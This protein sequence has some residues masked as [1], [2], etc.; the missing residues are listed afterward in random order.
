MSFAAAIATAGATARAA[1]LSTV[2][3]EAATA[4]TD[5]LGQATVDW[6]SPTTVATVPA[7]V[8]FQSG[9]EALRAGRLEAMNEGV[10]RIPYR[11]DVTA[12]MRFVY[13]G[14]VLEIIGAGTVPVKGSGVVEFAVRR[15]GR[16]A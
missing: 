8:I 12:A 15:A 11:E 10:V 2:T 6:S 14:E 7:S 1:M 9:T 3:V 13:D 5:A 16:V 4:T